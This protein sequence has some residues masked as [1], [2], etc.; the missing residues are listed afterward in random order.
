M[1][2]APD[3]LRLQQSFTRSAVSG[4][5]CSP[6]MTEAISHSHNEQVFAAISPSPAHNSRIGACA[7]SST[8]QI[9]PSGAFT[10]TVA[11]VLFSSREADA[12]V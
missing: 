6:I 3:R 10:D 12:E 2:G 8:S 4:Q 9:T 11:F 5:K 1:P 7:M